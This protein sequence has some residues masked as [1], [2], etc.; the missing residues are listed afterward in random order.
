[1]TDVETI[2]KH[3]RPKTGM[4]LAAGLGTR[5]RPITNTKPKPLVQVSGKTLLDHAL[6]ALGAAKV[7][8]AVVN[9]HHFA[10]QMEEHV[11]NRS[12]G[13]A[14][15]IS[16]ERDELMNSGGGVARALPQLGSDPFFLLNGDS[17]WIE[18]FKP[19]LDR[20]ADAWRADDMDMLL[21]LSSMTTAVGYDAAGDFNMDPDGRLERRGESTSSPFAYAGAAIVNPAIFNDAPEGAFN[22]NILFDRAI[23]A[24]RLFGVRMDGLWLHVGTP[25]AIDE[26]EKAISRS[27]A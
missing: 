1:M 9:V 22:L 18:G 23:Q 5:M 6:D 12:H 13:P 24:G 20:M 17:F 25:E 2:A 26:A 3:Q 10:D 14:V 27:A 16:D 8:T 19:N 4:V 11:A 15:V 21:L 7:E